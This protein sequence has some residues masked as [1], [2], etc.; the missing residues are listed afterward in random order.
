[1]TPD[2]QTEIESQ[3]EPALA[4]SFGGYAGAFAICGV[5]TVAAASLRGTLAESNLVLIYLLSVVLATARFGRG[6]GIMASPQDDRTVEHEL[7]R[8][9]IEATAR[10]WL[11]GEG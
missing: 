10:R 1:M 3:T 4:E 2:L 9:R 6:P 7:H 8:G 5:A 11:R